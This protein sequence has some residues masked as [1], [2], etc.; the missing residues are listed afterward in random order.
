M[1]LIHD[2]IGDFPFDTSVRAVDSWGYGYATEALSTIVNIAR[3][4]GIL[5]LY[6]LCHPDHP[7]SIRVLEKSG[8]RFEQRL[9][10]GMRVVGAQS[11]RPHVP[12][13]D[14]S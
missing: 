11:A 13:A 14:I 12:S 8:F 1:A 3:E 2:I 4:L 7:A 5:Q 10:G 9:E 6:A